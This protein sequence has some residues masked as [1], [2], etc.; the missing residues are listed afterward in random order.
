MVFQ[1]S[2]RPK[3][4]RTVGERSSVFTR[5]YDNYNG[6]QYVDISP[7]GNRIVTLDTTSCQLK[8]YKHE[9]LTNAHKVINYNNRNINIPFGKKS[10]SLSVSNE[11]TVADG[12]VETLIAVSCFG[13]NDMKIKK[14]KLETRHEFSSVEEAGLNVNNQ[15]KSSTFIISTSQNLKIFT[16]ID[17]KGGIIKFLDNKVDDDI[18]EIV[19]LNALGITKAFIKLNTIGSVSDIKRGRWS[20]LLYQDKSVEKFYFPR[21]FFKELK[22]LPENESCAYFIR[23][24][25]VKDRFVIDSY[26][27]KVQSIET[28]N[29]KTNKLENFFQKREETVATIIG[30]GSPYFTISKN[31]TLLAYC[32][33]TNSITIFLM[34][35]GLEV[36]TKQ[37]KEKDV[38]RI[39]FFDFVENDSKLLIVIEEERNHNEIW[40]TEIVPVIVIWDL[41]SSSNDCVR[42]IDDT[43]SLFSLENDCPQR[44]ATV[45]G[46]FIRINEDGMIFSAF[47]N[48][49]IVNLL[50]PNNINTRNVINL[51][52]PEKSNIITG[53]SSSTDITSPSLTDYHLIYDLLGNR[54]EHEIYKMIVDDPEPWV[55]NKY[56][57][58]ISIYLDSSKTTQLIVGESTVQVW[59]KKK[60]LATDTSSKRILEYIW[61]NPF[62]EMHRQMQIQSLEV[63]YREF[64]LIVFIPSGVSPNQPGQQV[65]IEWPDKVNV[66]VDV[67]K[68]L[69][70]LDQQ[71]NTLSGPKKQHIF[72]NMVQQTENIIKKYLVGNSGLWRMLDIRYEI[73]AHLIRGNRVS[74][75]RDILSFETKNGK[76]KHLHIPR[77]YS[78][79]GQ[80]KETDLEIAIKYTQG[81]YRKD[82]VIVKYLL[83][84]YSDNAT[85]NSNWMF[86]VS[87]AIPLL[88]EYRLEYYVKELFQKPCFGSNEIYL[89]RTDINIEDIISSDHKNVH[90]INIDT[91]L[92]KRNEDNQVYM[93]PLPDFTVYPDGIHDKQRG[94]W[95]LP[96][97]LLTLLFWPR[98]HIIEEEDKLSPFL[99]MIRNDYTTDVYDNPSIAAVIDFKWN[100]ARTYFVRQALTYLVFGI[101]YTVLTNS[102]DGI[103]KPEGSKSV[104]VLV[105]IFYWL[106]FYL[107]NTERVQLKYVGWR[108][109][110]SVYNFFDLFSVIL[111]FTVASIQVYYGISA[112]IRTEAHSMSSYFNLDDKVFT[113]FNSFTI[114]TMWI[115]IFLLLRYFEKTGAYIY[116]VMNI[117]QNIT[118]FLIFI[119]LV[120]L[121]F[122]HTMFVLLNNTDRIGIT[123]NGNSFK[124]YDENGDLEPGYSNLVINQEFD[125]TST[126][127]NY[128]TNFF[129]SIESVYF[130]TSGRWDQLDQWNFW[131]VDVFSIIASILLVTI[132]QNMLIAIMAG[133]YDQ[134]KEISKHAVLKYRAELIADYETFDKPLGNRKGDPRYIFYIGKTAYIEKWIERS[135]QYRESYRNFLEEIDGGNPWSYEDNDDLDRFQTRHQHSNSYNYSFSIHD[136]DLNSQEHIVP[137]CLYWFVDEDDDEILLKQPDVKMLY[138]KIQS[139]EQDVSEKLRLIEENVKKLSSLQNE[140]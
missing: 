10:W 3:F 103:G 73:M 120:I 28:F 37:F 40:E 140:K 118:S 16:P 85:K 132:L 33:G 131:P 110:F 77:L 59:R 89:D 114:L 41:F 69:K 139:M 48:T 130:W 51:T 129:K 71:S 58:R 87:K 62:N 31:E 17:N 135:E 93:V 22:R 83:D 60:E 80:A 46:K 27:D 126:S 113:I 15:D 5:N 111:P 70:F 67:C 32:R 29:L 9:D 4:I 68:A 42:K 24:S 12:T 97:V 121:G 8:L 128:F 50:N 18:I 99:R 7:N 56:Y 84:Y 98:N 124:F 52:S 75:I 86:T 117:L 30:K 100:A 138:C 112:Y 82:T 119:L 63:A 105:V 137:L 26:K 39:T 104:L 11:F 53:T 13:D 54:I 102:I 81:G 57:H 109:Y 88:Y 76:N 122:G 133:A 96:I 55:Q 134:A 123:P 125:V 92:T 90:A 127:D 101:T 35:N 14:L 38:I 115:E 36:T 65:I 19:L 136:E 66:P 25:L 44:V 95:S 74:I 72:E 20:N 94:F 64:S 107:L 49:N 1:K 108:R 78:W 91:S 61:T 23:Q 2:K 34:E 43:S 45:S 47:E 6:N 21:S 79:N 116:I 106:G